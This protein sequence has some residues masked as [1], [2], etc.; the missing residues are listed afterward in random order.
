MKYY[1]K[2]APQSSVILN[3]KKLLRNPEN[4]SCRLVVWATNDLRL[5]GSRK[6]TNDLRLLGSRKEWKRV[7]GP[8]ALCAIY[9]LPVFFAQGDLE[10]QGCLNGSRDWFRQERLQQRLGFQAQS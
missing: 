4:R 5:P 2:G 7:I 3:V 10:G 9:L 1:Y 6:E 8:A